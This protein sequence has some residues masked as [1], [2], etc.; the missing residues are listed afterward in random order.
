MQMLNFS[1]FQNLSFLCFAAFI[2][3]YLSLP[4]QDRSFLFSWPCPSD[5]MCYL[6][7]YSYSFIKTFHMDELTFLILPIVIC[8][9]LLSW[10]FCFSSYFILLGTQV[11]TSYSWS[12]ASVDPWNMRNLNRPSDQMSFY[13]ETQILWWKYQQFPFEIMLTYSNLK[14]K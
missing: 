7:L 3:F 13:W 1:S 11:T 5:P 8:V 9:S 10:V 2:F 4:N 12:P 6:I 14:K